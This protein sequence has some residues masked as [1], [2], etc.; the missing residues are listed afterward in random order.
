MSTANEKKKLNKNVFTTG[1]LIYNN[2]LTKLQMNEMMFEK[3]NKLNNSREKFAHKAL[4]CS[5]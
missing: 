5:I 1:L 4:K 3:L 2:N